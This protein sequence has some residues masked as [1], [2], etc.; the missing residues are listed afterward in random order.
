M[1][2]YLSS[3][4]LSLSSD[5]VMQ[6]TTVEPLNKGHIGTFQLS[7]VKRLSFI[8]GRP[9]LRESFIGGSTVNKIIVGKAGFIR[10]T[11]LNQVLSC[12][13]SGKIGS[14]PLLVILIL[15][16]EHI[17]MDCFAEE[18]VLLSTNWAVKFVDLVFVEAESWTV[19]C[20]AVKTVACSILSLS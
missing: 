3:H 8:G 11:N 13:V 16:T 5:Y 2:S 4:E 1:G 9:Y 19:G 14:Q 20:F 18:A 12:L 10:N 6:V 17:F 7:L 15:L